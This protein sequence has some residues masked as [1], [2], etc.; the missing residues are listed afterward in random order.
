MRRLAR[1]PSPW[2]PDST[3]PLIN[4]VLLLVLTFMIAGSFAPPLP[5][6]FDPLRATEGEQLEGNAERL[7]VTID[8]AGLASADGDTMSAA[9]AKTVFASAMARGTN[10]E[11]RADARAPARSVIRLMA[12][13]EESGIKSVQLVTLAQLK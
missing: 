7:V 6:D 2:R 12:L 4:V 11:L 8:Q 9:D 10:L 1:K 3:L 13:A 5:P